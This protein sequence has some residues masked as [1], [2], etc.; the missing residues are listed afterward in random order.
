MHKTSVQNRLFIYLMVNAAADFA[1]FI[2]PTLKFIVSF[3]AMC[4]ASMTFLLSLFLQEATIPAPPQFGKWL[5]FSACI[6]KAL[7]SMLFRM[8]LLCSLNLVFVPLPVSPIYTLL[9]DPQGTL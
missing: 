2:D 9:Q 7:C 3:M 6:T 5:V 8:S 4:A 1:H